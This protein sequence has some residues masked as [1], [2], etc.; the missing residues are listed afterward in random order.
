[1]TMGEDWGAGA[2][3][4]GSAIPA[5]P[6]MVR[7]RA[8]RFAKIQSQLE[9]QGIDG[10]VL[11][12]SGNVAYATGAGSP[13]EDGGRAGLFRPVAVVVRGEAAPHVYTAYW[14]GVPTE[15]PDEYVHGPLF[16]DLD[17]GIAEFAEA[18]HGHFASGSRLGVD[19]QTH[20]MLRAVDGF[21]WTEA[22]SVLGAAKITKTA[23]EV[24]AIRAAQR[25]TELA[26]ETV[27]AAL[28]P[29]LRQTD[30]SGIFLRRIFELGA[31]ANAIDPIWQVMEPTKAQGP[32]TIH[33]DLA[34]PTSTTDRILREGDIIWVDAGISHR[35]YASD[36]GRTWITSA[37][38]TP[39]D[40]QVSH[41]RRWL[42]VVDAARDILKPGVSALE[43]GRAAIAANDG[44]TPWMK[45]FYL[46]H[47]IGT[48]SAEMPLVGTDLGDAFDASLLMSPGM[49]LVF[50][51]VIWDDGYAGYRSEDVVAVTDSGWVPLSGSHY[52]P[53][54]VAP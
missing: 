23:D 9:A 50:E 31:T 35:G 12:G 27:R 33:G 21:A 25:I 43:L 29:G 40:R 34:Y 46:A 4:G 47:G 32:W 24:S 26:M 3:I 54:V 28:R 19:E 22:N 37:H 49:V 45:H 53:F 18:L 51:P 5:E 10:L 48:D 11:L 41:F 14:D 52:D 44:V 7:L 42:A 17:D 6:D 36:F 39:T 15:L 13:G 16:P 20:P 30:L 8:D 1:M 38:P 2:T